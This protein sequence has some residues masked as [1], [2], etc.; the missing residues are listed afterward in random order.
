[1][2]ILD[3]MEKVDPGYSKLKSKYLGKYV[4]KCRLCHQKIWKVKCLFLG[5]L[6]RAKELTVG[7]DVMNGIRSK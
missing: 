7:L 4:Y 3:V 5:E 1:M 2:D 6:I